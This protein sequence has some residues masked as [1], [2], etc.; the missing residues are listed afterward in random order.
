MMPSRANSVLYGSC[1]G[2]MSP[3][4][5][6]PPAI[7][8][9]N[10]SAPHSIEERRCPPKADIPHPLPFHRVIAPRPDRNRSC[11]LLCLR[12]PILNAL[13]KIGQFFGPSLHKLTTEYDG[14]VALY[15]DCAAPF[16]V[17]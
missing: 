5:C 4:R 13:K 10:L 16:E 8:R 6:I 15:L 9:D 2:S 17:M 3:N 11:C 12:L 1:W 7:V 14:V